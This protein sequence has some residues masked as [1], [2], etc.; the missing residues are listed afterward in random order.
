MAI[1]GAAGMVFTALRGSES[2]EDRWQVAPLHA[3]AAYLEAV[4]AV[5]AIGD[6]EVQRLR[7]LLDQA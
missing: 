3:E 7:D 1:V 6:A 5:Q 2:D 4:A